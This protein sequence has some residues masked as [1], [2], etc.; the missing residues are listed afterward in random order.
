MG[1]QPAAVIKHS[2][3]AQLSSAVIKHSYQGKMSTLQLEK[4]TCRG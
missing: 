1:K 4:Q 3:Q 2:Y